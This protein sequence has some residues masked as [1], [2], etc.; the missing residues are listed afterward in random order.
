MMSF[1]LWLRLP[2]L[3]LYL[4]LT[5]KII[6]LISQYLRKELLWFLFH[7]FNVG[8]LR[9]IDLLISAILTDKISPI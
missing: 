4:F 6:M 9:Y 8:D 2:K 5:G 1:H 3:M 7:I